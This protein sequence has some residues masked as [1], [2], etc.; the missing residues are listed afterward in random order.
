MGAASDNQLG[1]ACCCRPRSASDPIR[2]GP[3]R[4]LNFGP[5]GPARVISALGPR[6]ERPLAT[7]RTCHLSGEPLGAY[8]SPIGRPGDEMPARPGCS[9]WPPAG[10]R[11]G[12]HRRSPGASGAVRRPTRPDQ[13]DTGRAGGRKLRNSAG[14]AELLGTRRR[15]LPLPIASRA[16]PAP[17]AGSVRLPLAATRNGVGAGSSSG[18]ILL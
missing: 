9:I 16:E 10:R 8:L 6:R 4:R 17:G 5:E 2:P 11:P 14:G 12:R 3:A 7:Q 15:R 1:A 18:D 13:T